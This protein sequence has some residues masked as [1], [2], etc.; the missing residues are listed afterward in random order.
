MNAKFKKYHITVFFFAS[1]ALVQES[2]AR[3]TV[4]PI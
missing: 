3:P 4:N 2:K 1:V